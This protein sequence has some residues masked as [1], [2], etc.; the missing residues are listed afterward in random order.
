MK[1]WDL[2]K[3][4]EIDRPSGQATATFMQTPFQADLRGCMFTLKFFALTLGTFAW[5]PRAKRQL[6][7]VFALATSERSL[8]CHLNHSS[9]DP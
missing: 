7:L 9:F 2:S 1:H 8:F 3:W 6:P 4:C 5:S